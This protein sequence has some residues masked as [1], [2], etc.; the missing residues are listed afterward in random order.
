M[1][2]QEA[3]V[4]PFC[5]EQMTEVD[6]TGQGIQA[7]MA[8][9]GQSVANIQVRQFNNLDVLERQNLISKGNLRGGLAH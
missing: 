3:T 4:I 5:Y 8:T 9:S 1:E 7:V 6:K 2:T